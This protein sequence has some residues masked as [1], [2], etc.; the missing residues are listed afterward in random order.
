[1]SR[2]LCDSH[3]TLASRTLLLRVDF[4][5]CELHFTFVSHTGLLRVAHD[6][7]ESH[8]SFCASHFTFARC[9]SFVRVGLVRVALYLCESH[10]VVRVTLCASHILIVR[11][12]LYS[13]PPPPPSSLPLRVKSLGC[14]ANIH[15][16]LNILMLLIIAQLADIN[17]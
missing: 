17:I 2:T 4:S 14:A 15:R 5:F 3:V 10:F 9:K 16:R 12:A 13:A 7:C 6:F 11:V 1:V 8:F